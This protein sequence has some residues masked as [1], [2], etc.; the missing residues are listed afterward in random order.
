MVDF[1][2]ERGVGG[3]RS[4]D[5]AEITVDTV[6]Y[7]SSVQ[8]VSTTGAAGLTVVPTPADNSVITAISGG[9][10]VGNVL[11]LLGANSRIDSTSGQGEA[12][13]ILTVHTFALNSIINAT[14]RNGPWIDPSAPA[15]NIVNMVYN[16]FAINLLGAA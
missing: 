11:N 10:A 16:P 3:P 13:I 14:D 5:A 12:S 6:A 2:K 9:A 1:G 7:N 8:S 15:F 4:F